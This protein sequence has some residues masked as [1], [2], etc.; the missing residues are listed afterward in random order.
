MA[1]ACRAAGPSEPDEGADAWAGPPSDP[2]T[3]WHFYVDPP[4]APRPRAAPHPRNAQG[5]ERDALARFRQLQKEVE[6]RRALAVILP[7]EP[8]VRRYMELEAKVVR[9]ASLFADIAQRIAWSHP[10][11]DP[12]TQGRPVNAT[13]LEVFEQEQARARSEVLAR[14]AREHVLMFFFRGDC[15]YCHAMAPV[16]DAFRR[17]HGIRIIA[18]SADGG[19]LAGFPDARRDNGIVRT[20]HVQQFPALFLAQPFSGRIDPVGVGVLSEAQLA[21]RIVTLFDGRDGKGSPQP[22]FGFDQP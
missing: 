4:P 22:V 14:A 17:R 5:D 12:A 15:G 2:R 8:N 13:A 7:T 19:A 11:L 16:L 18:V 21:E 9:N 10:E 20:M 1:A 6:E 3:G